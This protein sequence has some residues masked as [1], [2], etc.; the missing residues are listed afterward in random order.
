MRAPAEPACFA[1][2]LTRP[3]RCAGANS[4]AAQSILKADYREDLS[5]DEALR[6]A[7]KVLSKTMDA[8]QLSSDKLELAAVSR[9]PAGAVAYHV[10]TPAELEPVTAAVNAAAAAEE[11]AK[12]AEAAAMKK[13]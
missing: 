4:A 13:Q 5:L 8:T 9:T 3:P 6:L 11:A 12:A 1:W 2:L 10:Y 7:V